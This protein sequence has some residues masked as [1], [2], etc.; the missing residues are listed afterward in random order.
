M[1]RVYVALVALAIQPLVSAQSPP[2][3]NGTTPTETSSLDPTVTDDT[4]TSE[5]SLDAS[6]T[7]DTFTADTVTTDSVSATVSPD[8]V[9]A[10][11]ETAS[12]AARGGGGGGDN[13]CHTKTVTEVCTVTSTVCG[14]H[15]PKATYVRRIPKNRQGQVHANRATI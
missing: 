15:C 1:R 5:T 11:D 3:Q 4:F 10:A 9:S 14:R 7:D 6:I 8:G 13:Y 12:A 2:F